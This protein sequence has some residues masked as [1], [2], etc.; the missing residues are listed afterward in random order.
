M[1][2]V[3]KSAQFHFATTGNILT[4]KKKRHLILQ[5][6]GISFIV[7][8]RCNIVSHESG[9]VANTSLRSKFYHKFFSLV[10]GCSVQS[11]DHRSTPHDALNACVQCH[12]FFRSHPRSLSSS[13]WSNFHFWDWLDASQSLTNRDEPSVSRQ[14]SFMPWISHERACNGRKKKP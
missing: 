9:S 8:A 2:C 11:K 13:K 7:D 14:R 6:L 4:A 5:L 3:F 10:L 1:I 12:S